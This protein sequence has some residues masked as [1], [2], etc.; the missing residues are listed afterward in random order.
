[1][2]SAKSEK[3]KWIHK[4]Q[5]YFITWAIY[6][7]K[8]KLKKKLCYHLWWFQKMEYLY[9]NLTKCVQYPYAE[10]YR[11]L[12]KGIKE[13]LNKWRDRSCLWNRSLYIVKRWILLKIINRF[14]AILV[15]IPAEFFVNID[16]LIL[17]AIW[18]TKGIRKT[19]TILNEQVT[20]E[21]LH[22]L[23]LRLQ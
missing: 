21:E 14:N 5:P 20:L 12:M 22:H 3:T 23:I 9:K 17:K 19:K 16:T 15:K 1:M 18:K 13:Q 7:W 2:I 4:N 11:T 6:D 8:L 10:N